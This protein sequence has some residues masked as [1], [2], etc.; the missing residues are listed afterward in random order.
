MENFN[1]P[2]AEIH[3]IPSIRPNGANKILV[4]LLVMMIM[5]IDED[6]DCVEDVVEHDNV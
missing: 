3:P 4:S 6:D 2:S 5:I 1:K